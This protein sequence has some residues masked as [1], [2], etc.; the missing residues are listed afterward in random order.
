MPRPLAELTARQR[1]L[2][3]GGFAAYLVFATWVGL[4]QGRDL[5]TELPVSERLLAGLPVFTEQPKLGIYWTPFTTLALVPFAVLGTLSI[6]LAQAAFA[7]VNVVLLAWSVAHLAGRWGWRA[8]SLGLLAVAKPVHGNFVWQNIVILVLACV[9]AAAVDLADGRERRAGFWLGVATALKAFPAVFLLY[10]AYRRRWKGFAVGVGV[11]GALTLL[12]GLRYGLAGTVKTAWDWFTLSR[13]ADVLRG[14]T[15][16]PV[17]GLLGELGAPPIVTILL[18]VLCLAAVLA[19]LHG[20]PHGEERPYGLGLVGLLVLLFLPLG[21]NYNFAL[22][23]LAW[24]AALTLPPPTGHPHLWRGTLVVAAVLLSG[25][26]T[27][28]RHYNNAVGGL[29]LLGAL[30]ARSP[31]WRR[32]LVT[33]G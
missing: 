18:G 3:F 10:L 16:Q 1:A 21:W 6:K 23:L 14:V 5:L 30:V 32:V 27:F 19:A 7:A 22:A 25:L 8:A 26:V 20:W 31:V 24:V 29:L 33:R 28:H 13:Q 2:F 4:H 9:V 12:P 11:A 17:G 15:H